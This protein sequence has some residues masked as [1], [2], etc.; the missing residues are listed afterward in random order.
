MNLMVCAVQLVR[1]SWKN[2]LLHNWK[3]LDL[4]REILSEVFT[5][6]SVCLFCWFLA[7]ISSN[8]WDLHTSDLFCLPC[9]ILT[10]ICASPFLFS[11]ILNFNSY[12]YFFKLLFSLYSWQWFCLVCSLLVLLSWNLNCL[13]SSVSPN[14]CLSFTMVAR[15]FLPREKFFL[16]ST[17]A[18]T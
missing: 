3:I 9:W 4:S 10:L 2:C 5:S 13:W 17:L 16:R 7:L 12:P 14:L 1:S 8:L 6:V 11:F 15:D 18:H